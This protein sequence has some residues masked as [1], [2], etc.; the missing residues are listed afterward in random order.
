MALAVLPLVA[1]VVGASPAYAAPTLTVTASPSNVDLKVG[2]QAR[3]IS[4]N[5]T[6]TEPAAGAQVTIAVPLMDKGVT[7]QNA[8]NCVAGDGTMTC[9]LGDLDGR[10]AKAVYIR[11]AP[12]QQ[13]D[14]GPGDS[15]NGQGQVQAAAAGAQPV[16]AGYTMTLSND[17]PDS[18]GQVSGNV[19]SDKDGSPVSK[20]SVTISD[21][22]GGSQ[23]VTT[24]DS[25]E[26]LWSPTQNQTLAPGNITVT[27]KA[28]GYKVFSKSQTGTAGQPL[29]FNGLTLAAT[30]KPKETTAAASPTVH[31]TPTEASDS[32]S[33][34]LGAITWLLIILGILLVIGGAVAIVMLLKKKDDDEDDG[35]GGESALAPFDRGGPT[36]YPAQG[37]QH[38]SVMSPVHGGDSPTMVHDGPL[39]RDQ[40]DDY[41]NFARNYGTNNYS[42]GNASQPYG[43]ETQQ[44]GGATQQYGGE[45]Q[46]YG[47]GQRYDE[48][49]RS[50]QAGGADTTRPVSVPPT[51]GGAPSQYGQPEPSQYGQPEQP[52]YGESTQ[53]WQQSDRPAPSGYEGTMYGRSG[54]TS[55]AAPTSGPASGAPTSGPSGHGGY[56]Q[57]QGGPPTSGGAPYNSGYGQGG[58]PTS[59]GAP[60]GGGYGQ[61]EGG[62]PTSGAAPYNSGYG[63]GGSPTSGGAP[64]GGGYGQPERGAPTSGGAPYESGYGQPGQ[65]GGPQSSGQQSYGQ[66]RPGINEPTRT[67]Q[68]EQP[69]RQQ[70][71]PPRSARPSADETR[72]DREDGVDWLDG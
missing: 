59:G 45:T 46:Q 7:I 8:P 69:P 67:W 24:D 18:V 36:G 25:G 1:A 64:Y 44:Y 57:P 49:T 20:A 11:V 15:Q 53:P 39:V 41:D 3:T 10:S 47:G 2:G 17:K 14:I 9:P 35:P 5:V 48:A 52:R 43:G 58:S 16:A 21:A 51:S 4:I 6:S 26:F 60:Y 55:G 34:G 13:S 62:A 31:A 22:S 61:S 27:V 66:P 63:Q 42:A 65:Y 71:Q 70:Q 33:G 37:A 54:P 32:D 30:A 72:L 56:G 40:Y 19:T 28:K 50:W 29:S 38:T 12:P 23:R 68:A